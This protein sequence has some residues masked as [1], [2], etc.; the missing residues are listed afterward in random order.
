MLKRSSVFLLC[1]FFLCSAQ[2]G[3]GLDVQSQ[4][5]LIDKLS[6]VA[7]RLPDQDASKGKIL[8]RLADLHS[9]RGRA[10]AKKDL[11]SN[12]TQCTGGQ[13]DRKR[14]LDYYQMALPKLTGATKKRVQTQVGHLYELLGQTNEAQRFYTQVVNQ[15]GR[16]AGDTSAPGASRN[17][18]GVGVGD[19][20]N[21]G[22]SRSEGTSEAHFSLAEIYFKKN[23]FA[24]AK[25]AYE[26]SLAEKSFTRRGLANYRIAWCDYNQGQ[27]PAALRRLEKILTSDQLLTRGG[28]SLINKDEDF[29]GEVAKDYT[30]FVSHKGTISAAD[31]QKV[32]DLSPQSTRLENV[33]FLAK[34]LE[35]LGQVDGAIAAWK[36]LIPQTSQ[37]VDRVEALVYLGGVQL[38]AKRY[39][40]TLD[41]FKAALSNYKAMGDCSSDQC[42]ELIS[43]MRQIV[44]DWNRMEKTSPSDNLVQAYSAYVA[45]APQD[46]EALR[47]GIQV[48]LQRKDYSLAK[49][50]NQNLIQQ[51]GEGKNSKALLRA[52]EI[53][54]LS[55]DKSALEQ[56]QRFYVTRVPAGEKSAEVLYNLAH[57]EYDK[58]NYEP[59][60]TQ[61]NNLVEQQGV[62]QKL[63]LQSAEL[64]LDSL[65][66]LKDD[67]RIEKYAQA[68]GSRFPAQ[69]ARFQKMSRQAILS[70]AAG[71]AQLASSSSSSSSVGQSSS[72]GEGASKRALSQAWDTL[73]RFQSERASVSE[74]TSYLKNKV[75][76]ARKLGRYD[77]LLTG[78]N[79]LLSLKS[80]SPED[81]RFAHENKVYVSELK[82]D[83]KS[84]LTSY[85][86]INQGKWIELARLSDLAE[87]NSRPYYLRF[88]RNQPKPAMARGVCGQLI[89]K[90]SIYDP[91]LKVCYSFLKEQPQYFSELFLSSFSKDGQ[92]EKGL[93]FL[94]KNG[95]LKTPAAGILLREQ[96]FRSIQPHL[97]RLVGHKLSVNPQNVGASIQRRNQLLSSF[98]QKIAPLVESG[99]WS[100][101]VFL[102]SHL[103]TEQLRFYNELIQ[104]P[105]PEGLSPEE[106]Q[107]YVTLLGGQAQPFKSKADQ[108]ELKLNEISRSP[109][110]LD[111]LLADY[112]NGEGKVQELLA[113]HIAKVQSVVSAELSEQ[114]FT[115][116]RKE[117]QGAVP[118]L[119]QLEQ[120]RQ[121]VQARPYDRSAL[122][123][124]LKLEKGRGYNP[125]VQ[126][127]QSRMAQSGTGRPQVGSSQWGQN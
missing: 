13:D 21:G 126:Y 25:K 57:L 29:Q 79:E 93:A 54:E 98:E 52:I 15:G 1:V 122:A 18:S 67:V 53:A 11:E 60:F 49:Q 109:W 111:G 106:Q 72:Q 90:S 43:R 24:K 103:R 83:F 37:P 68:Y 102:L 31:I 27:I 3:L 17:S 91:E 88:L 44:L 12:C 100:L 76:L 105:P 36:Q 9:E 84:A 64:A 48:A 63:A 42:S 89:K 110:G 124:L 125:I 86:T 116:P 58:K 121:K 97:N 108:L 33:T 112:H 19:E 56:A 118:S 22:A 99:D 47:L 101:Q 107:Q 59:A 45:F 50:W 38:Q 41:S 35:R 7:L 65:V 20:I 14:A 26:Q 113:G 69:A 94:R 71:L 74:K 62:S 119:A 70:Q 87:S 5:L 95:L 28:E 61:F 81:R 16:S 75:I 73:E 40:E 82:L 80:L 23:Q 120:A 117:I 51:L 10:L 127:L 34:E 55:G 39:D 85:K 8:L 92:F 104:L 115:V 123:Q 32:A 78:V 96:K 66:L 77:D 114:I 6:A 30:V 46:H 4:T 2:G